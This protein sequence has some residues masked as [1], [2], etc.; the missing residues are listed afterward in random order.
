MF[1]SHIPSNFWFYAINHAVYLIN[2]VPSPII[3]NKTPFELLY[4]KVPNFEMLKIFGCLCYASTQQNKFG[5]RSRRG[6]F[7]GFQTGMK[8][9]IVLDL[10]TKEIFISRDVLFD[11]MQFLF[12]VDSQKQ[13]AQ[14]RA[15]FTHPMGLISH[16][17]EPTS[18]SNNTHST[19]TVDS[20][21]KDLSAPQTSPK[22]QPL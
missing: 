4:N 1:Q 7:L 6:V 3:E 8:G 16:T 20:H 22:S 5:P 10:S 18:P 21:S 2:R 14:H 9:H 13:N 15:S 17:L 19:P 11:E 12:A